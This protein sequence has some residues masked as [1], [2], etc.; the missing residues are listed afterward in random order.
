MKINFVTAG[1]SRKASTGVFEVS[2]QLAINLTEEKNDLTVF[3]LAD[4]NTPKDNSLWAP[5]QPLGFEASF[6][7]RLGYSKQYLQSL[8]STPADVAHLHVL[9]M[10]QSAM[11]YKWHLKYKKPFITTVNAMLDP[12]ALKNSFFKKRMAHYLYERSA[13]SA[14]SCFQVNTQSEYEFARMYGLKNP[15]A[16][17]KNG[18]SIPD[19]SKQYK[20]PPWKNR[21]AKNKKILLYL[22]R[23]HP[24]KGIANLINALSI[25]KKSDCPSYENWVLVIVGCKEGGEHEKE[26]QQLVSKNKLEEK[27]FFLGQYFDEDMQACYYHSD[28]YILPT[29]SDGMPLAALNAW[30][31]GKYSLLTPACHLTEGYE[32]GVARKIEPDA[33][34]IAS[35]LTHLFNIKEDELKCLGQKAHQFVKREYSWKEMAGKISTIYQWVAGAGATPSFVQEQ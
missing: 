1:L 9:W 27:V 16:I 28:A 11:I 2:R 35:G 33:D 21:I 10:Y 19:L 5:I 22:S 3:G 29:Y 14:C 24:K 31:F 32:E 7:R 12:W 13:M 15:V 34:D 26:L 6:P 25:L 23:V 17:V 20:D 4:D 18:I 30:A 8:L